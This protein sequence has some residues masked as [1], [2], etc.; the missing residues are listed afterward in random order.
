MSETELSVSEIPHLPPTEFEVYGNEGG[1]DAVVSL[2]KDGN[3]M[4]PM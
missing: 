4:T 2:K 3:Y 1:D